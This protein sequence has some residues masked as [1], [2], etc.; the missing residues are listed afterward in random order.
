MSKAEMTGRERI[1]ATIRHEEPDRV[2]VSP[3]VAA[4]LKAEFGDASLDT[5]FERLPDMDVMAI[6]GDGT[7]NTLESYPDEYDLPEVSVDQK[8]YADGQLVI[9]E[10]TFRT[11]AGDISDRTMIPPAGRR[12]GVSPNPVKTDY[13]VKGPDDL[14]ALKYILHE[15]NTNFDF[16]HEC[17]K[18]VGD[19][20]VV[21]VCIRS[22]LDHNAGYARSMLDLMTDYYDNRPFFDELLGIFHRRSLA[23]VSAALKGGAEII[24]GSWYFNSLSAGWSPAIFSEVF[25]PQIRDHVVLTHCYGAYYDYYDDGKL[26]DSMEMIADADVDVLE[27]CTPAPVG[28]FN[29]ARAKET[30]GRTTTLKGYVDL[31]YVVKHGSTELVEQTVRDAMAIAK[32]GGGFIIGS[33]DSF[34]EGT[35]MENIVA[36]FEACRKYGSYH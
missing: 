31:L 16:L 33:S 7:P 2:P 23:Q 4:W 11:P 13:L 28:D 27:T 6:V 17:R 22:A 25:V 3:R 9:V 14:P 1:L 36:Y 18:K 34:R 21:M 5:H 24:F 30:I 12:Y 29:L 19:R 26:D 8:K 32:P 20:G 10:R 15:V 35:P